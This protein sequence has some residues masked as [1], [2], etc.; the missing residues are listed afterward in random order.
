M[1]RAIYN[2]V[3]PI[4]PSDTVALPAVT[5]GI[6]VGVAGD[7]KLTLSD[8]SVAVFKAMP[9]GDYPYAVEQVWATGTTATNILALY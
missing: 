4:I 9:V 2:G 8:G 1:S 5:K 3:E 6:Y 7:I